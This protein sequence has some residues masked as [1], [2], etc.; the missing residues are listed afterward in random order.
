MIVPELSTEGRI[1]YDELATL[2]HLSL[3]GLLR[4][5]I[6][7]SCSTLAK[8]LDISP[9]TAS[10]RL[11]NFEEAGLI[12]REN[13]SDG[14][15]LTLTPRGYNALEHEYERYKELFA[16]CR[17]L[18]LAGTV[19]NGLDLRRHVFDR[20]GYA[21]QFHR[22]LEYDPAPRTIT[23]TLKRELGKRHVQLAATEPTSIEAWH[24]GDRRYDR[25]SCYPVRLTK[26]SDVI[27][28]P[29]H[30][31]TD[32]EFSPQDRAINLLTPA[33]VWEDLDVDVGDEVWVH[34]E[35]GS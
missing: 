32:T 25:L 1:E 4:Y 30:I 8:E 5:E 17:R 10:R 21:D 33:A 19:A 34:V 3:Q 27:Y 6:K 11:Q 29:A 13:V 14:Q 9:Q 22:I 26:A 18:K 16:D 24:D 35:D 20:D 12:V 15:F 23:V 28:E 7:V 2:T 31:V